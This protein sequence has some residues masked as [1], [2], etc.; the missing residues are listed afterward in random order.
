MIHLKPN[1]TENTVPLTVQ[2]QHDQMCKTSGKLLRQARTF[3]ML[4]EDYFMF[5]VY[6]DIKHILYLGII[7]NI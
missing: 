2:P 7:L 4:C 6:G 5:C 3:N 1:T